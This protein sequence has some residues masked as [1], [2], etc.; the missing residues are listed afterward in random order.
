[1]IQIDK[2]FKKK[3][4]FFVFFQLNYSKFIFA[5]SFFFNPIYYFLFYQ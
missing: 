3:A 2:T 4:H 1:M 5:V